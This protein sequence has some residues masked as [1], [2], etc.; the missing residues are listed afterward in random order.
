[1]D[2]LNGLPQKSSYFPWKFSSPKWNIL[3]YNCGNSEEVQIISIEKCFYG[4]FCLVLF[5]YLIS[6]HSVPEMVVV[7]PRMSHR[8]PHKLSHSLAFSRFAGAQQD[9]F[10]NENILDWGPKPEH[11]RSMRKKNSSGKLPL[12]KKGCR[13]QPLWNNVS[14]YSLICISFTDMLLFVIFLSG[15]K[16]PLLKVFR[17]METWGCWWLP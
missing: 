14:L 8:H 3:L 12:L 15:F 6:T 13:L 10:P 11:F 7:S 5:G 16:S 4:V 2:L 9:C 1:M 17:G